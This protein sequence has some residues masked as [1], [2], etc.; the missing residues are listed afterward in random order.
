MIPVN[1]PTLAR[2]SGAT[3]VGGVIP[4][5]RVFASGSGGNQVTIHSLGSWMVVLS[6][7]SYPVAIVDLREGQHGW[8]YTSGYIPPQWWVWSTALIPG[9]LSPAAA[10][11]S[12]APASGPLSWLVFPRSGRMR[13]FPVVHEGPVTIIPP[14]SWTAESIDT[15]FY[16]VKYAASRIFK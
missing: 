10:G 16:P 2:D 7:G 5:V 9:G 13:A 1:E 6:H 8:E 3:E 11:L 4:E 15:R 12:Y 14:G